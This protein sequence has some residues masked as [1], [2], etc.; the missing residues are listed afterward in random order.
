MDAKELDYFRGFNDGCKDVADFLDHLA[1][2]SPE[3]LKEMTSHF[4]SIASSVRSKGEAALSM[5]QSLV[6]TS[7]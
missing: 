4:K 1:D 6:E 3:E 7:Q 2:N 5:A